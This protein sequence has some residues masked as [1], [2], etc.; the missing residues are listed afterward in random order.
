VRLPHGN[1]SELL[2]LAARFGV[3]AAAGPLFSA[4]GGCG[5]YLRLTFLLDDDELHEGVRRLAQAWR[6]YLPRSA[7]PLG[8]V[9]AVV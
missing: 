8:Q 3:A 6:A 1:A 9:R 2:Q 7:Q 5:D 4:D